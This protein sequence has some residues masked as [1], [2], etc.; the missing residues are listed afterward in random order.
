MP[1]GGGSTSTS[2]SVF[3]MVLNT[4]GAGG[5]ASALTSAQ[6]GINGVVTSLN[7]AGQA[8]AAGR[9]NSELQAA[10]QE[11][12]TTS[13]LRAQASLD[14]FRTKM[15][16]HSQALRDAQERSGQLQTEISELTKRLMEQ[17]DVLSRLDPSTR[18]Y[19]G[20]LTMIK[21][22]IQNTKDA[23]KGYQTEL[24]DVNTAVEK[25]TQKEALYQAQL[26]ARE[27]RIRA[28]TVAAEQT[29]AQLSG[30]ES[31]LA[32]LIQV[33]NTVDKV[34]R[35]FDRLTLTIQRV[36]RIWNNF[37]DIKNSL[38]GKAPGE[39]SGG[40]ATESASVIEQAIAPVMNLGKATL[41]TAGK[42]SI[43]GQA[44]ATALGQGFVDLVEGSINAIGQLGQQLIAV[45]K[46]AFDASGTAERFII[47]LRSMIG[48][49]RA[50]ADATLDL[51]D[52][53]KQSSQEAAGLYKWAI[54]L[55]VLSPFTIAAAKDS[56]QL[57]LAYQFTTKQAVSMTQATFD[58]GAAT[59]K[60]TDQ[61][62]SV[63]RM[64]GQMNTL[65]KFSG[66]ILLELGTAG[67]GLNTVLQEMSKQTGKT[68]EE[69]KDLESQG[70]ITGEMG[71]NAILGF[72]H[73]FDGAA[74][75]QA[76]TIQGLVES[77]QEMAP[78]LLKDFFGPLDAIS[79]KIGGVIG[80]IQKRMRGLV[81]FLQ[82][83]WI[84]V[85]LTKLGNGLGGIAEKAFT[86]GEN[87]VTQFANGMLAAIGDI[88]NAL[89]TISGFIAYWLQPGSP[90]KILPDIGDWGKSAINEFFKGF[91]QGDFSLFSGIG[92]TIEKHLRAVLV[93]EPS[94]KIGILNNIFGERQGVADA[95]AEL[96]K[97]GKVAES[98]FQRIFQA[99]GGATDETQ[100]FIR[101][102][103]ALEAQNKKVTVA[104]Q[105]LD[106]V[107]KKYNDLL[108]PL[109]TQIQGITDAQSDLAAEQQ[110]TMLELILKD[111]NATLAEKARAKLAIDQLSA[112]EKQRA[113]VT[114]AKKEV[115]AAQTKVDAETAKQTALQNTLE[116]QK[117][118]LEAEDSQVA[119]MQEYYDLMK[120]IANEAAA[121]NAGGGG[122]D[123]PDPT[124]KL[125]TSP[126]Q[127]PKLG[128]IVTPEWLADLQDKLLQA[129]IMVQV[130][131]YRIVATVK[132]VTDALGR[133]KDSWDAL[134][135]DVGQYIPMIESWFAQMTAWTVKRFSKEMPGAI[136]DLTASVQNLQGVWDKNHL[137]IL[138]VATLVWMKV[139][140]FIMANI[141][142]FAL[143]MKIITG[144]M[145]H[146]WVRVWNNALDVLESFI[147]KIRVYTLAYFVG[148]FTLVFGLI[149][150]LFTGDWN[151]ALKG[152]Y[153][154]EIAVIALT[155][156]AWE[157]WLGDLTR[158]FIGILNDL[159]AK[160]NGFWLLSY[161][162]FK[163]GEAL[164]KQEF[165][166]WLDSVKAVLANWLPQLQALWDG[167]WKGIQDKSIKE[168]AVAIGKFEQWFIDTK[169]GLNKQLGDFKDIGRNIIQGL[170]DGAGEMAAALIDAVV[171]PIQD[172]LDW[173][174]K[175]LNMHSPSQVMADQIGKPMAQGII[176]G[177]LSESGN[178]KKAMGSLLMDNVG[179]IGGP[180]VMAAGASYANNNTTNFNYS[181]TY[182]S[183][184]SATSDNFALM[185]AMVV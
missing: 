4:V 148:L 126:V 1:V 31:F 72:M 26:A 158:F 124:K 7:K 81:D 2:T 164:V 151:D 110:K 180:G 135:A 97:T 42:F 182:N 39:G 19:S 17:E 69:L 113:L 134:W 53:I 93:K 84:P 140:E 98:T 57:A 175:L 169:T 150:A 62:T 6:N 156:M 79:G 99:M 73:K 152:L 105:A 68:V 171:G 115:D 8:A 172:A 89:G 174:R 153:E 24:G 88:L 74:K 179:M 181:P 78:E 145:N 141:I 132:P 25:G 166:D 83:D 155:K 82:E 109:E 20:R 168:I 128:H 167:L 18:G 65:G 15:M 30:F 21:D 38:T 101:T 95:V 51:K 120:Q 161:I 58:W 85:V 70:K 131:F 118:I 125:D 91:S 63:V 10:A 129:W 160:W 56:L 112:E 130:A 147:T 46:T 139:F 12:M 50:G 23:L 102:S 59:G 76:G 55:G 5:F 9:V 162:K 86:W 143:L 49:E 37:Q 103:V 92:D 28:S 114:E 75:E 146:D 184:P 36:Q 183:A 159:I 13:I 144:L 3:N 66:R 47:S 173:A 16:E 133:L 96:D 108:K 176:M 60:S 61:V 117:S 64:L 29:K 77:L 116:L 48:V 123:K 100:K 14:L 52:A 163:L 104:Q 71:I 44:V 138:A 67:I 33:Y 94:D 40:V 119:L 154:V 11:K 80:V 111:P 157:A 107:T 54:Q 137:L 170:I 45:G 90:P 149:K 27:A 43:L 87:L 106:D 41:D 32:T 142:A 35:T 121:A 136:D 34:S 177:L 127:F 178:V 165:S 185:Q 22:A 122:G